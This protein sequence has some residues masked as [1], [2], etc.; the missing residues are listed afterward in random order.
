MTLRLDYRAVA[1]AAYQAMAGVNLA[2]QHSGLGQPLIDLLFLRIS[3]INGCAYC[4]DKH[5][6][7]L[8]AQGENF[9]RLQSLV[10]WQEAPCFS[11]RERAAL[12]WAEA[13]TEVAVKRAPE[14][15]YQRLT[16][17]F[18]ETDIAELG[19][20]IALMNA[21]NRIAIGF[22]QTSAMR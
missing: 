15:L 2:L 3:Q 21:W 5:S 9:Q 16:L 12:A 7:D 4:V 6:H 8:Q 10:C 1:P 20:V 19:F 18:S 22:G 14:H 13:L 17:H 11:E